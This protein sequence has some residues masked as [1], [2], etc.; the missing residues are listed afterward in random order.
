MSKKIWLFVLLGAVML[1][2]VPAV[3]HA[4]I[5]GPSLDTKDIAGIFGFLGS[6]VAIIGNFLSLNWLGSDTQSRLNFLRA[7][8]WLLVFMVFFVS[9]NIAFGKIYKEQ[10]KKTSVIVAII[11]ATSTVI[12]IPADLL[13]TLYALYSTLGI[14]VA[15]GVVIGA[16]LYFVYGQLDPQNVSPFVVH[17]LRALALILTW[18]IIAKISVAV[19]KSLSTTTFY[20]LPL[21]FVPFTQKKDKKEKRHQN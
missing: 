13:G 15:F 2:L 20:L 11:V 1:F 5:N 21:I 7:L 3:V 6:I 16:I 8:L 4:A 12:F 18:F 10:A 19:D 14:L 9:G 17:L